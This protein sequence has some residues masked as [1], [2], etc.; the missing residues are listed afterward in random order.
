MHAPIYSSLALIAEIFVSTAIF[1]SF[2]QGYKHSKFPEKVAIAALAYETLFNISYMVYR[3]PAE[4]NGGISETRKIFGATHGVLSLLMFISLIVFFSLALRN[5][6][7]GV[8]YFRLHK[9]LTSIFLFFWSIS[10]FSG[11]ALYFVEYSL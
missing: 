4:K 1:Y 8:N 11:I 6:R 2:Y 9:Y 3:L 10:V 5:Y 7:K